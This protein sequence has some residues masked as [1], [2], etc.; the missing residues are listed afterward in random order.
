MPLHPV[1]TYL[2]NLAEIHRTG[3][4]VGDSGECGLWTAPGV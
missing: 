3:G 2:K 4:S 1:E